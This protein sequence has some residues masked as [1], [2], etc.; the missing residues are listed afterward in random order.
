V[1]VEDSLTDYVLDLLSATREHPEI[2]LGGSTRAALSLYRAAQ[3]LALV[4]ARDYVVPDD[5]KSLAVP[6]LAHRILAR[7]APGADGKVGDTTAQ[8]VA[9]L[10]ARTPI[11]E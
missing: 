1:R 4:E 11:P 8:V 7:A 3:A 9:D 6:I 2:H 10:V 5:I